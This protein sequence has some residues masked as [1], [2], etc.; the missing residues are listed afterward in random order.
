MMI[1]NDDLRFFALIK[2]SGVVIPAWIKRKRGKKKKTETS[3]TFP[4]QNIP[5]RWNTNQ[6]SEDAG[7][8]HLANA[9]NDAKMLQ[10]RICQLRKEKKNK[11]RG[12]F[13]A[14]AFDRTAAVVIRASQAWGQ[15]SVVEG[16]HLLFLPG[17]PSHEGS[18]W[19]IHSLLTWVTTATP[20]SYIINN[21]IEAKHFT[22][23]SSSEELW[24]LER[25]ELVPTRHFSPHI[26]VSLGSL[27]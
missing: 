21:A 27:W 22:C 10:M 16:G 4:L 3:N 7:L 26:P 25:P 13:A 6:T 24:R 19:S 15:P 17:M 5:K 11:R 18:M 1:W 2:Y 20:T 12:A 8:R 23:K 9:N 14:S